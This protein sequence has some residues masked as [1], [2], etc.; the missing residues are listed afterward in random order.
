LFQRSSK[1]GSGKRW[2]LAFEAAAAGYNY[3]P[4]ACLENRRPRKDK[5][6]LPK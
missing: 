5:T 2:L 4:R 6:W 1:T 3:R